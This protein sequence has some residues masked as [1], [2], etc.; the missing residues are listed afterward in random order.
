[1]KMIKKNTKPLFF[2][3]LLMIMSMN[4]IPDLVSAQETARDTIIKTIRL[5]SVLIR[6]ARQNVL[7]PMPPIKGTYIFA[8]K[9]TEVIDLEKMDVNRVDNNPRQIFSKVPG[10][11]VYETDGSGNQ[12]NIASRGLDAHRS[13]EFNVRHND[14]MTNTDLY[15]YPASHFSPPTESIQRIE[16]VRGSGSLQYGA[17]FGG[18]INYITKDADTTRK[19][20]LET[21]QSAGSFGLFSSFNALGGKIAKLKYDTYLSYR[22]SDGYRE[23]SDYRY[24]SYHGNLEY[25]F[26]PRFNARIE[27]NRMEYTNH[28]NGGL[29]DA[30]FYANSRQSTR[31]RNYYSPDIHVPSL[32]LNYKIG[33]RTNLNFIS[34]AVLGYRNSVQF[35]ALSTV[36]DSINRLTNSY[37]PRQVDIDKYN[38]YSQELR[39]SHNYQLFKRSQTLVA[40]LRYIHNN[41][42]RKQLGRGTTGSD[43]DLTLTDPTWGRDLQYKTKNVSFF[44][45]SLFELSPKLSLTGGL[46]YEN[47]ETQTSGVIKNYDTAKIPVN[48]L[49][50]FALLG[51]GAQ[52]ALNENVTLLANWSQAYRPV[53]FA[54]IIPPT[55][56][57][58]VDPNIRDAFGNNAELGVRGNAGGFLQFDVTLFNLVYKHRIGDLV[59]TNDTGETFFYKT[60]TG[61]S[62]ANGIEFY[63]EV[64]P[65]KVLK[66]K[67]YNWSASLFTSTAYLNAKYTQGT[68][69]SG[70]QN[71][72]ITGNR[73]EAAPQ[74][75]SRNGLQ[76]HYKNLSASFQ[77]SFVGKSF[78]DAFNTITPNAS[79]TVG[80]VPAYQ[81]T[82]VNLTWR[83]LKSYNL[84]F[85][86]N[87]LFDKRYFTE[88][89]SFFPG[90]GGLY[91][92]DGRSLIIS[93]GAK[94]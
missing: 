18:M 85:S 93:I 3:V 9:K 8:G 33:K 14:V 20:S 94:L 31:K 71:K 7:K 56:L 53:I 2:G 42:E 65:F 46:R 75:V 68:K 47:G 27:Y 76:L 50:H 77:Y 6:D 12:V 41:L 57:N 83:F 49:H 52:Y 70:G 34:S 90:P 4:L 60:N 55:R 38:S 24:L 54:D 72:N 29:N 25:D 51:F 48:I 44:L 67:S 17:Q 23:N 81:L 1:M 73:V 84:K 10:I 37:N 87:N 16:I 58:Q 82:D 30:Q 26:T 5:D 19:L 79:G 28:L 89:P 66:I 88:R 22:R 11:F 32:R 92:S 39:L 69:V 43:Y 63:A 61:N 62:V 86:A 74:W 21:Q 78:S 91:P 35:I 15:G 40:G 80:I 59:L 64:S 36:K 45:E 13:W